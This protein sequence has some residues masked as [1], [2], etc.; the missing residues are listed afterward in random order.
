MKTNL[1]LV[2]AAISLVLALASCTTIR[3]E[4]G[5]REIDSQARMTIRDVANWILSHPQP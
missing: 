4:R 3:N 1:F 2:L 5:K